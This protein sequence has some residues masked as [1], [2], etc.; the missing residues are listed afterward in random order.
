MKKRVRSILIS[1]MAGYLLAFAMLWAGRNYLIF[2]GWHYAFEQTA[3]PNAEVWERD[4]GNAEK[5]QAYFR[6]PATMGKAHAVVY[7][8]GNGETAAYAAE[9]AQYY[10]DKG[11]A[12]LA[13]E[14]RGYGNAG[15][16]PD[17]KTVRDDVLYFYDAL[18]KR[19]DIDAQHIMVHGYSLGGAF[20]AEL[21]STRPVHALVLQSTFTSMSKMAHRYLMPGIPFKQQYQTQKILATYEKPVLLIHG[22]ADMIV[23]VSH[24]RKLAKTTPHATYVEVEGLGHLYTVE[25][26]QFHSALEEFLSTL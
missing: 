16:K 3:L 19:P 6:T 13:V 15:G 12:F 25:Q 9:A 21:A 1:V 22:D 11:Y 7:L 26:P 14:Y 8:H 10:L 24:G 23:P 17:F 20:A 2:P 4:I 5:V 18:A